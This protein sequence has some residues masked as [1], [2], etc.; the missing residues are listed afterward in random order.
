MTPW[1][2]EGP[3]AL[4]YPEPGCPIRG[5]C[6]RTRGQGSCRAL[7]PCP[8]KHMAE[9]QASRAPHGPGTGTTPKGQRLLFPPAGAPGAAGWPL[10]PA[11]SQVLPRGLQAHC[12]FAGWRTGVWS[13][14]ASNEARLL[15]SAAW[16]PLLSVAALC[17]LSVAQV[18]AGEDSVILDGRGLLPRCRALPGPPPAPPPPGHLQ[19]LWLGSRRTS[20]WV[21]L[22][23]GMQGAGSCHRRA[24]RELFWAYRH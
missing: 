20:Q 7:V 2:L 18:P 14:G 6:V 12:S 8:L 22:G 23:P 11:S 9:G 13:R 4:L 19:G 24:E 3:C 16:A 17:L 15:V 10:W 5:R 1:G 21:P